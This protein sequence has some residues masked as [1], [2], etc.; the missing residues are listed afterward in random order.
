MI[1]HLKQHNTESQIYVQIKINKKRK[2][3]NRSSDA[4]TYKILGWAGY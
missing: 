3:S 2:A 1:V 4:E